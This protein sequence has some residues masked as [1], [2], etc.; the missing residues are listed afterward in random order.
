MATLCASVSTAQ[1]CSA[2]SIWVRMN[3]GVTFI[4]VFLGD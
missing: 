1:L 2:P 4:G 3:D